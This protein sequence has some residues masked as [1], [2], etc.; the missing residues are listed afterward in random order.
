M[1]ARRKKITAAVL[2]LAALAAADAG[3]CL[4]VSP[5]KIELSLAS[6]EVYEGALVVN[7]TDGKDMKVN[8]RPE[9]WFKAVEGLPKERPAGFAWLDITPSGF[10]LGPRQVKEAA[11]RVSVPKEASGELN[12]MI[13]VE[14]RP[15]RAQE[16]SIGINTSI[17]IPIYVVIKGTER[18]RAEIK[19]LRVASE[20]PLALAVTIGNSGNVHIRPRGTVKISDK[21]TKIVLPLNEYNYP[22]LPFSDRTLEIKSDERLR[23][24][25]Y[26][27]E[28]E[29]GYGDK[30]R[31][32]KRIVLKIQSEGR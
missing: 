15:A 14:A 18:Y 16:G 26:M 25:E 10:E 13:F 1:T 11:Y 24:G 19:G 31:C 3:H 28:I 2:L 8:I 4:N 29:M 7:N 5:G 32:K 17:G 27:A 21:K 22:V 30:K 23:K 12:G 9:D 20:S 6:S